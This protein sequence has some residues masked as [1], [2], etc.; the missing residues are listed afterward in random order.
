M[1]AAGSAGRVASGAVFTKAPIPSF[2]WNNL[3]RY[4]H[5]RL[6]LAN[7]STG[8]QFP[9]P[10]SRLRRFVGFTTLVIF[11]FTTGALIEPARTLL[12]MATVGIP[13]D[14]ETLTLFQPSD[15]LSQ[16]IET[17]IQTHPL[18][19]KYR[20]AEGYTES[21][22]HMKFPT[23]VRGRHLITGAL[24]GPNR[25]V[26]PPLVFQQESGKELIAITYLGQEVCGHPGIVHGGLLATMLDEGLARCCFPVLPNH[27]GVTANLSIDYKKPVTA[28]T[29]VVLRAATVKHEG[30]KAWVEGRLETLPD[31]DEEPVVLVEAK[32]LFIEPK[33]AARLPSLYRAA[34]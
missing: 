20:N 17:H 22:P 5:K 33:Y 7:Y 18:A 31:G 13:S 12:K 1:L 4:S 16:Q 25:I 2:R 26:V 21:R 27:I 32:G 23:E 30:R 3:V 8:T 10:R 34:S 28:D 6:S 19:L 29:Y 15:E 14:E 24:L 9:K 11:A